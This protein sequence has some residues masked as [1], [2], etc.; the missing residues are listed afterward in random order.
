M[1]LV[2][3]NAL[4]DVF[5]VTT[6]GLGTIGVKK[7][8]KFGDAIVFDLAKS[9]CVNG[10]ASVANTTFFIGLAATAAPM[11]VKAQISTTGTTPI[12]SV[13]ARVP[14]HTVPPPGGE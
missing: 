1:G 13:D 4:A 12:Y 2:K 7:A 5:V 6:G 10:P 9:L 11:H 14:T 3:N 8:E